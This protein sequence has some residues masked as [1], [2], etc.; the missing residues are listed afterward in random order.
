VNKKTDGTLRK[1]DDE[2]QRATQDNAD[3]IK[4]LTQFRVERTKLSQEL[5]NVQK[6]IDNLQRQIKQIKNIG[7]DNREQGLGHSTL[8]KTRQHE[9]E[10]LPNISLTRASSQPNIKGKVCRGVNYDP[11]SLS[12]FTKAKIKDLEGKL[13]Q[14]KVAMRQKEMLAKIIKQ[15]VQEHIEREACGD[16][17]LAKVVSE[18]DL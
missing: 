10:G 18:Y 5:K 13:E 2:I 14:C 15:K 3:L 16:A 4:E 7:Q 1:R 8:K 12:I 11:G 9:Q 6:M 17:T